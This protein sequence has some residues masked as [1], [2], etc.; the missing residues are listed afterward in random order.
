MDNA[1]SWAVDELAASTLFAALGLDPTEER[2]AIVAGHF[3]RHR[4]NVA[5][6]AAERAQANIAQTL[7]DASRD[8]FARESEDWTSG[9]RNAEQTIVTMSA[10]ELLAVERTAPLSKGRILRTMMKQARNRE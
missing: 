8:I 2:L 3:A 6:W 1:I 9:F 10:E 5:S 4:E 7:E